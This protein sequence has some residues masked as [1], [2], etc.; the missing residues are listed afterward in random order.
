MKRENVKSTHALA[1][2]SAKACA[3][4]I[5]RLDRLPLALEREENREPTD[6]GKAREERDEGS[7]NSHGKVVVYGSGRS[8]SRSSPC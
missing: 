7:F 6:W 4:R 1:H 3:R 5:F 8:R 2:P